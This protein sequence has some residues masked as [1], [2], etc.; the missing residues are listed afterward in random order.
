[1]KVL[2]LYPNKLFFGFY[3]FAIDEIFH[4]EERAY[5]NCHAYGNHNVPVGKE[6]C[7]NI[8][9]ERNNGNENR[10]GKLGGNVV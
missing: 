9:N 2:F 6:T 7:Y 5:H 10:V 4:S 3:A 1:M 8:A